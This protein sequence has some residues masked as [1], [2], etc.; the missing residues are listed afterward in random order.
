MLQENSRR[1]LSLAAHTVIS[2]KYYYILLLWQGNV[3]CSKDKRTPITTPPY[4]VP[5]VDV[6]PDQPTFLL[7]TTFKGTVS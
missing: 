7:D 1:Y 5:S 6:T 4:K 3:K 2:F